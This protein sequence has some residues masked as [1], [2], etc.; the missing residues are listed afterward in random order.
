MSALPP[1]ATI[2]KQ[3]KDAV[4]FIKFHRLSIKS[5]DLSQLRVIVTNNHCKYLQRLSY[6]I[7][8]PAYSK[9]QDRHMETKEEQKFYNE[10][11]TQGI[12]DLFYILS[13]W[14][15]AGLL[16]GLRLKVEAP[17]SPAD[18]MTSER[19]WDS[20]YLNLSRGDSIPTISNISDLQTQGNY[21]R[22]T[23]PAVAP[24]LAA[25]LLG[26]KHIYREFWEVGEQA[27]RLETRTSFT[28]SLEQTKLA[29]VSA[30]EFDFHQEPPI[31][32]RISPP[33]LLPPG[34]L[35]DSLS[36]SLRVVSWNLTSFFS[37]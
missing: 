4:E 29:H 1:Y 16:S 32:H 36:T 24:S 15:E 13:Q 35:Y 7:L 12:V 14:E 26:L 6:V 20:T 25:F 3:W 9:E 10:I 31:D 23:S 28:K 11:F 18:N 21:M 5:D 37:E 27:I 19:R 22:K 17:K 30:A 2:S 34:A 8:L 33:S